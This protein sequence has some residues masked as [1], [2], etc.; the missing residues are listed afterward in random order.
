MKTD[1][2]LRESPSPSV[3]PAFS[4]M[5]VSGCTTSLGRQASVAATV[6]DGPSRLNVKSIFCSGLVVLR[7]SSSAAQLAIAW[8]STAV[9]MSPG[10]SPASAAGVPGPTTLIFTP[11]ATSSAA[12]WAKISAAIFEI[13]KLRAADFDPLHGGAV[14]GKREHQP[15]RILLVRIGRTEREPLRLRFG[16]FAYGLCCGADGRRLRAFCACLIG[17]ARFF[18]C[19][20]GLIPRALLFSRLIAGLLS[21][22]HFLRRMQHRLQPQIGDQNQDRQ[23]DK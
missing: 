20:R 22:R 10:F 23:H 7:T 2:A 4:D 1:R 5:P 21:R 9:M 16:G 3:L 17:L 14:V 19:D 13:A 18:R 6:C 15:I 8:P 11:V 12:R